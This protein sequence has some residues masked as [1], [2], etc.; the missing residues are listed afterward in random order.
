MRD[1]SVSEKSTS[2]REFIREGYF[3]HGISFSFRKIVSDKRIS[4]FSRIPSCPFLQ[5][6]N[7]PVRFARTSRLARRFFQ[8]VK[9][10]LKQ[11]LVF[12]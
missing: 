4:W 11:N 2:Y 7:I 1:L 9:Q 3:P 6:M 10:I 8:T 5:T 12:T